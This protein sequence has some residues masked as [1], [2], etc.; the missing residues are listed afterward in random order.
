MVSQSQILLSVLARQANDGVLRKTID[1]ME[2]EIGS[3]TASSIV[4]D[5]VHYKIE[6]SDDPMAELKV[7][8]IQSCPN[9]RKSCS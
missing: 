8:G 5:F 2:E 3:V 6:N 4:D 7:K 1:V 9:P